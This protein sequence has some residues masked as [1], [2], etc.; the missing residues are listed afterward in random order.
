MG[1]SKHHT[2]LLVEP[3]QTRRLRLGTAILRK[4]F[5]LA[6]AERGADAVEVAQRFKP[7]VILCDLDDSANLDH[8]AT[9]R[10]DGCADSTIIGLVSHSGDVANPGTLDAIL[11]RP[12]KPPALFDTIAELEKQRGA[13]E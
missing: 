6:M 11:T 2:L 8:I 10:A 1:A 5:R 3:D 4:G 7:S 13:S 12:L 9:L